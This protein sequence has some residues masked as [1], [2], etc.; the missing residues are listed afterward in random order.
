MLNE[1]REELAQQANKLRNGLSKIDDTRMKVEEMT[2]E[3]EV[4]KTQG[5]PLTK[6]C[7]VDSLQTEMC[8]SIILCKH[9]M[10]LKLILCPKYPQQ[11]KMKE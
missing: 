7:F 8:F 3:L 2:V 11:S 4:A 5:K 1:K 10:N 6:A 9:D